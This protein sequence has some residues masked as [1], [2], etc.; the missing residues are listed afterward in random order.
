MYQHMN[1]EVGIENDSNVLNF[2]LIKKK[3]GPLPRSKGIVSDLLIDSD[4]QRPLS[5]FYYH[6]ESHLVTVSLNLSYAQPTALQNILIRQQS[7]FEWETSF[8]LVEDN[9]WVLLNE[10]SQYCLLCDVETYHTLSR[11]C[12]PFWILNQLNNT[13]K[14]LQHCYNTTKYWQ[15]HIWIC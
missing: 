8:L 1:D 3:N 13:D 6:C 4:F 11:E 9:Q 15:R 10:T 7:L 2:E 14:N 12:I 5:L